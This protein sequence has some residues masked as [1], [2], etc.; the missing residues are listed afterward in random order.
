[1]S[2]NWSRH[3]NP[4]NEATTDMHKPTRVVPVPFPS[5]VR[6]PEAYSRVTNPERFRPLHTLMGLIGRLEAAFDVE[7]FE[8]FG[9][10]SDLEAGE[11]ARPSVRLVPRARRPCLSPLPLRRSPGSRFE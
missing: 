2:M 10:D 4:T 3:H 7:R 1:M 6:P 11:L 9:L 8:G 5:A